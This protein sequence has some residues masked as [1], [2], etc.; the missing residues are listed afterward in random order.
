MS[1][2]VGSEHLEPYKARIREAVHPKGHWQAFQLSDGRKAIS[3]FKKANGN[4]SDTLS[5][6]F[7]YVKCGNDCTLEFG[8]IGAPFYDSM[9]SMFSRL[10]ETLIKQKDE[11]LVSEFMPLLEAEFKRV[12]WMGWG[13]A[14]GL[15]ELL[16]DLK[17]AFP[18]VSLS[19][20]H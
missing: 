19:D 9:L 4:L 20:S 13:Y 11:T 12:E 14:D 18:T 5:L 10:V 8:D 15:R 16:E 1:D 17:K 3:E 7:Y 6:M 2:Q